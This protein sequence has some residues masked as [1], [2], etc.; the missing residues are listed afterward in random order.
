MTLKNQ[1]R[2]LIVT[3]LILIATTN[4]VV[5]FI[6]GEHLLLWINNL[7]SLSLILLSLIFIE[8][9][10]SKLQMKMKRIEVGADHLHY[11]ARLLP[12]EEISG[13]EEKLN[14]LHVLNDHW[15]TLYEDQKKLLI[16]FQKSIAKNQHA[17]EFLPQAREL[18][19]QCTQLGANASEENQVIQELLLEGRRLSREWDHTVLVAGNIRCRSAALLAEVQEP[20]PQY[21]KNHILPLRPGS[22]R[23][24]IRLAEKRVA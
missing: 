13:L 24:A 10:Y 12:G 21:T 17:K 9:F 22:L 18:A 4:G 23:K 8:A 5:Q 15:G 1:L 19:R 11:A 20:G 2:S 14:Q 6:A 7:I 16:N 3:P